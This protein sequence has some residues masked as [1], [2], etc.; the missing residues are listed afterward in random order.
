M[1]EKILLRAFASLKSENSKFTSFQGGVFRLEKDEE[2]FVTVT[3]LGLITFE[4]AS[5]TFGLFML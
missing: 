5:T 2:V 3:D 1:E 4:E